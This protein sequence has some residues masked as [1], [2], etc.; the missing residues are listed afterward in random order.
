M[1]ANGNTVSSWVLDPIFIFDNKM[2][3]IAKKNSN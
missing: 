3:K 1:K 2:L